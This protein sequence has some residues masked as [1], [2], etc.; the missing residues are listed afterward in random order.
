M[1]DREF[2]DRYGPWA[3]IAGGS[4]GVGSAVAERLA[5]RGLKL[6]LLA[7]KP[8]PLEATAAN[9]RARYGAEVRT[10]SLDLTTAD[11]TAKIAEAIKGCQVG[12]LIYN[13]G[14]DTGFKYFVDRPLEE[15][16]RMI[17]LNVMTPMRLAR[18]FAPFMV[19]RRRGCIIMCSSVS[20][21]GG[22]PGNGV[23]SAAKSFV[24]T[25][26]EMLW[27]EL[28]KH[29]VDVLGA[30]L[31]L[32]RT[33]AMERLG[34]K[35]DGPMGASDPGEVAD[36]LLANI[37]S[38]PT[39]YISAIRESAIHIRSLPRDQAVLLLAGVSESVQ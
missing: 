16:E 36:E 21:L 39:L 6:L 17:M 3:V 35:F 26:T 34:L 1:M 19:E 24:N 28:G 31:G 12:S 22:N 37:A 38:G 2:L 14:A 10:L 4:E 15:S 25:F 8:G 20:G 11:C 29:S 33:P 9:L 18:H 5:E 27:Y 13:A 32:T 7:R 30:V 23:Y